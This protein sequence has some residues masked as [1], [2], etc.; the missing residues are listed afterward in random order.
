MR[1]SPRRHLSRELAGAAEACALHTL[2]QAP[3]R[4]RADRCGPQRSTGS[5]LQPV[6]SLTPPMLTQAVLAGQEA[7]FEEKYSYLVHHRAELHDVAAI[8]QDT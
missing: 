4:D 7:A 5:K 1:H 3:L 2:D 6:A 8:L